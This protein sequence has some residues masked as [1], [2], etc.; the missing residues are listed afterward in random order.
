MTIRSTLLAGLG[1]LLLASSACA[2]LPSLPAESVPDPAASLPEEP[3]LQSD[4]SEPDEPV[5]HG[6]PVE[7]TNRT[8]QFLTAKAFSSDR[9]VSAVSRAFKT[10]YADFALDLLRKATDK[11]GKLLSPLSILTCLQMAANGAKGSTLNEMQ[12]VLCGLETEE[13]NQELYSYMESLTNTEDAFLQS[14]NAAWVTSRPDFHI[15]ES[16]VKLI[17]NTFRADVVSADLTLPETTDA[18]NDW[19]K[20]QTD[21]MIDKIL[22]QGALKEDALMVLL[23]ALCFDAAWDTTYS[24]Y[25]V[26]NGVFHGEKGDTTVSMMSSKETYLPGNNGKGFLKMYKG[27]H[28]AFVGLLPDEGVSLTDYLDSLTGKDWMDLFN[29]SLSRRADVTLPK[30]T[31]DWDCSLKETLDTLGMKTVFTKDSD[32]SG[33]GW[34]D[35]HAAIKIDDVLHK[36]H[37]EVDESGTRAAA[38]TAVFIDEVT[39]VEERPKLVFDRPFVYAIVDTGSFLPL[40]IGTATNIE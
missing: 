26:S 21:G 29:Y 11:N 40:F 12:A 33:L 36:T 32:L 27:G 23:N 24:P 7:I 28:Y 15:E 25:A 31:F 34:T 9:Q 37:I 39:A 20:E 18:I 17:E 22:E 10:G 35:E 8:L 30:F 5:I 4:H 6:T 3:S 2:G 14:A 16:F 38:V 19:C 1:L 13:L